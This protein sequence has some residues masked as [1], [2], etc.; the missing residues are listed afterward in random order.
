MRGGPKYVYAAIYSRPSLLQQL[1]RSSEGFLLRAAKRP[2]SSRSFV[3]LGHPLPLCPVAS[4][5]S[6]QFLQA[7]RTLHL[8]HL[9]AKNT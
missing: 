1:P 6:V 7:L 8:L 9:R 4:G 5:S 2:L 3:I